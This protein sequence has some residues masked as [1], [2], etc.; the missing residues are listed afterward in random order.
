MSPAFSQL[1]HTYLEFM[2]MER[3][4]EFS[5]IKCLFTYMPNESVLLNCGYILDDEEKSFSKSQVTSHSYLKTQES[6]QKDVSNMSLTDAQELNCQESLQNDVHEVSSANGQVQ[7]LQDSL[8][9]DVPEL[10]FRH[11]SFLFK[12][13]DFDLATKF[14]IRKES[15]RDML[16][17]A[18]DLLDTSNSITK[19]ASMD[20]CAR[21][22]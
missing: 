1:K 16:R 17:K 19:V 22:F 5:L 12:P 15:F 10:V 11:H 14:N 21:S 3:E 20:E 6:S 2:D 4:K 9:E 7:N 8:L 18:C 13:E